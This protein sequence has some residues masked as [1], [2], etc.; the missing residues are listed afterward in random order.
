MRAT[1]IKMPPKLFSSLKRLSKNSSKSVKNVYK[2]SV[3]APSRFEYGW[4]YNFLVV[5]ILTVIW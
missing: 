3:E 4:G 1:E 5:V 2:H